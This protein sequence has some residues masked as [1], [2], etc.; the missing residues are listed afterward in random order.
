MLTVK[1]HELF[2]R[3]G[4][5]LVLHFPISYSQAALGA[6]VEVPTLSGN[7]PL[8]IDAGTQSGEVFRLRG[9]GVVEPGGTRPVICW[10]RW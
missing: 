1:P 9:M 2:Q 5:D 7:R 6:E 3:D 8:R 4:R 10:C